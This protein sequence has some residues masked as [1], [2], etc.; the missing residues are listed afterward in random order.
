MGRA[1]SLGEFS[2]G[3]LSLSAFADDKRFDSN[4]L[5]GRFNFAAVDRRS[6]NDSRQ[7][8]REQIDYLI[9]KLGE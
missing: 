1:F 4:D 8:Q 3:T 7:N 6:K 9:V 2:L 5:D